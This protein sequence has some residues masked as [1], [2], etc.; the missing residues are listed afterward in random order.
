M[1]KSALRAAPAQSKP[2]TAN[3]W[4]CLRAFHSC[5]T[6]D[7]P[8]P[9]PRCAAISHQHLTQVTANTD[10]ARKLPLFAAAQTSRCS[11]GSWRTA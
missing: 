3:I 1:T 5:P 11:N 10:E 8:E 4:H 7:M 6:F 2:Q 9:A